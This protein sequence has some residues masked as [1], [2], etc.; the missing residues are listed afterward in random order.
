MKKSKKV[1]NC[2][3]SILI[4]GLFILALIP[5]IIG[6]IIVIVGICMSYLLDEDYVPKWADT[7]S[8]KLGYIYDEYIN[9][10]SSL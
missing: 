9:L 3:F 4:L 1:V 7:L 2:I 8:N 5:C 6:R 10:T